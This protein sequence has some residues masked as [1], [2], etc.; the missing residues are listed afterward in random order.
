MTVNTIDVA[1]E[2]AR[3]YVGTD[4]EDA[5]AEFY[6]G[7]IHTIQGKFPGISRREFERANDV[8]TSQMEM[9][10][11]DAGERLAGVETLFA[12]AQLENLAGK[13]TGPSHDAFNRACEEFAAW[14]DMTA[15]SLFPAKPD[16]SK[17]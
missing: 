7:V 5:D 10:M 16:K 3:L 9:F 1:R 14:G 12:A 13:L 8:M 15:D 4:P 17:S 6:R 11:E 2:L